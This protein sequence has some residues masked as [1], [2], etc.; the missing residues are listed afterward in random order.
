MSKTIKKEV[1]KTP[2]TPRATKKYSITVYMNGEV[3]TTKT[4]DIKEALLSLKPDFVHTE[5]DMII[6]KGKEVFDRHLNLRQAR[7]LFIN[8]DFMDIFIINLMFGD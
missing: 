7:N 3:Y 1:K 2:S 8:E 6:T 5:I 4:N